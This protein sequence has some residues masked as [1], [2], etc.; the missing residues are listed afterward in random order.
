MARVFVVLIFSAVIISSYCDTGVGKCSVKPSPD[1]IKNFDLLKYMGLWYEQIRD[2]DVPFQKGECT[3]AVYTLNAAAGTVEVLNSEWISENN[4]RK[5]AK[6]EATCPNSGE[7]KCKVSFG[8]TFLAA[9][10]FTKGNYWVLDTDYS[11]YS[12]VYSC[13][14]YLGIYHAEFVWILTRERNPSTELTA[15]LISFVES[16]GYS[17]SNIRRPTDQGKDCVY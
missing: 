13:S 8:P 15:K 17:A 4:E 11:S 6:G 3:T 10:D 5:S 16:L 12:V 1:V 9:F 2:V 7:A 14:E